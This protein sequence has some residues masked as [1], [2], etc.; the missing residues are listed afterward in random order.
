MKQRSISKREIS[1]LR[2]L[3]KK[4]KL[5]FFIVLS[6]FLLVSY[7]GIKEMDEQNT[8][9][10][11]AKTTM[12]EKK[13][14]KTSVSKPEIREVID[15][16]TFKMNIHG[17]EET[18][19]LIGIDTPEKEGYRSNEN[20]PYSIEAKQFTEQKLRE[21]DRITLVH[22]PQT[23]QRDRYDRLLSYVFLEKNGKEEMLNTTLL[24]EGYA[25]PKYLK[26]E[27]QYASTFMEAMKDAKEARRN[28]WSKHGYVDEEHMSF[29]YE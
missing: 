27:Y 20:N 26:D 7:F 23:E 24:S 18:I 9:K 22:E 19:R 17:K 15:G 25:I 10:N 5:G 2:Q 4:S 16:D 3:Y 14:L 8:F 29:V 11:E 21:S 28:I 12:G 1:L 13:Q 6:C